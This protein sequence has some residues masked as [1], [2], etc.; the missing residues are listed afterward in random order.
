MQATAIRAT[1]ERQSRQSGDWQA[2][3]DAKHPRL[4]VLQPSTSAMLIKAESSHR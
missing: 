1:A 2:A 3:Q 4:R